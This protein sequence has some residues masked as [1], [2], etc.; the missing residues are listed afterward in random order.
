[1]PKQNRVTPFGELIA[2]EA[3]GTFMG[4][5]GCLHNSQQQIRRSY[6]LE[7][8]IICVLEFKNRRRAIMQ[9]GHYT[10]L[11]FGDEAVALAA[12]HRPCAECQR[13]R[14]NHFRTLWAQANPTLAASSK[15]AAT[16]IDAALQAERLT[17]N[18]QKK[19]YRAPLASLPDATFVTLPDFA[20]TTA[21]LVFRERLYPW[22]P[23]GYDPAIP[24]PLQAEV[25][26]LTPYSIVQTLAQGYQP[27]VNFGQI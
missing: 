13:E 27:I 21:F 25:D 10:E 23:G 14:F 12:G 24:R 16:V 8:W 9:P 5:R 3:R 7:R 11:F 2:T 22:Q 4:N 1:M 18:R 19:T 17:A 20:K 6:Q 26:V 15:P